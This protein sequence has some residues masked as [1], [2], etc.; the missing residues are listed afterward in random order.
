MLHVE[1]KHLCNCQSLNGN[2]IHSW[3]STQTILFNAKSGTRTLVSTSYEF[4]RDLCAYL[5]CLQAFRTDDEI[6]DEKFID[7]FA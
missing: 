2:C 4:A 7:R 1:Q 3:D 6:D 5:L